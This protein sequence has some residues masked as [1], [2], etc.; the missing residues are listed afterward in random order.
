MTTAKKKPRKFDIVVWG[1]TGFTGRLV[2]EHLFNRFGADGAISWALGGR[3]ETRLREVCETLTGDPQ[4]LPIVVGDGNDAASVDRIAARTRVVCA[5]VGPFSLYGSAMVAACARNGTDYCD[6]TGETQWIRR[7]IDAHQDEAAASGARIV[8]CCGFDS[9]PSDLG[10]L[11]L[12]NEMQERHG[13]GCDEIAFRLRKASGA[14]SGGTVASLINLMEEARRDRDVRRVLADPYALNPDGERAGPDGADQRAPAYDSAAGG[15]TA[16]FVMAAINTR[17]VRRSNAL[18]DYA[19]GRDFRYDEAV[20]CGPGPIGFATASATA[21]ALGALFLAVGVAPTRKLL[22]KV[23]LPKPGEGP[24]AA[25]RQ[26]G[27]FD[28]LMIGKSNEHDVP[29][30]RARVFGD[31][32]PG[33]GATSRMLGEAAACLAQD[34]IDNTGGFWTP[35]S[36]LGFALL[37]RLENHA[38]LTFSI[39]PD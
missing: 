35:A 26:R 20:L 38:G 21:G 25:A 4:G 33:Y 9:V 11:Y 39:E 18:L 27:F 37:D 6:I 30:L 15:W 3:S 7:M 31:R 29:D 8:N 1:A 13:V 34:D 5:T 19:Y 28:I 22:Q 2:A 12:Q 36:S 23:F 17:V 32:D 10:C 16:P 24:S 14:F